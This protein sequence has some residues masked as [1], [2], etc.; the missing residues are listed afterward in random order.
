MEGVFGAF[1]PRERQTGRSFLNAQPQLCR[2]VDGFRAA[3]Q[4]FLPSAPI[5]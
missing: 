2:P 1:S 5:V 4:A 3:G